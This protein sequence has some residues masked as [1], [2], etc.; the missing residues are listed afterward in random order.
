M[1]QKVINRRSAQSV[2]KGSGKR[3]QPE[4]SGCKVKSGEKLQTPAV[5]AH[6]LYSL[7]LTEKLAVDVEIKKDSR[8]PYENMDYPVMYSDLLKAF[9]NGM[10]KFKNEKTSYDPLSYGFN[11]GKALQMLVHSFQQ[12]LIPKD[13]EFV[14]EY[15]EECGYY[16][17]VFKRCFYGNSW[18][19]FSVKP[20]VKYW[21]KKDVEMLDLYLLFMQN[22]KTYCDLEMWSESGFGYTDDQMLMDR[23][24]QMYDEYEED[25]EALKQQAI[26]L[27][28]MEDY[29]SGEA[30]NYSQKIKAMPTMSPA[31]LKRKLYACRKRNSLLNW[32]KSAFTLIEMGGGLNKFDFFEDPEFYENDGLIYAEQVAMPWDEDD[33]ISSEHASFLDASAQG[34]GVCPAT[35][36]LTFTKHNN[37]LRKGSFDE[38]MS[39]EQWPKIMFECNL[40]Y[41]EI[42]NSYEPEN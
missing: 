18:Q 16:I 28:C 38:V 42:I 26:A 12:N 9:Q 5:L 25:E 41:R 22:F 32:M 29:E 13:W 20:V 24:D 6:S 4:R 31:K 17:A 7:K 14:V 27:Q 15:K 3:N 35:M 11:L 1:P 36:F 21:E 40:S 33:F 39:L 19:A 23:I 34:V 2:R 8:K 10:L 30:Y 37:T